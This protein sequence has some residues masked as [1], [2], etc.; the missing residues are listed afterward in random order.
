MK[1]RSLFAAVAMLIVSAVVLTSA[2]Y[3]WFAQASNATVGTFSGNVAAAGTGVQV[4]SHVTGAKWTDKLVKDDLASAEDLYASEY[5][6]CSTT[7]G[8]SWKKTSIG[9][10]NKYAAFADATAG[11][12]FDQYIFNVGTLAEHDTVTGTLFVGGTAGAAARVLV[13][14]KVGSGNWTQIGYFAP[15]AESWKGIVSLPGTADVVDNGDYYITEGDLTAAVSGIETGDYLVPLTAT[16]APASG[17]YGIELGEVGVAGSASYT[18]IR[19]TTWVEG[20]DADCLAR[21]VAG[22]T[23]TTNWSFVAAA[24]ETP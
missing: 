19:V 1:K 18:Q 23:I 2:T 13:E 6:P 22:N 7:D 11:T 12:D 10:G 8:T 17:G 5:T 24:P 15:S 9:S 3:A 21:T 16:A 20:N 4:Q 14:K